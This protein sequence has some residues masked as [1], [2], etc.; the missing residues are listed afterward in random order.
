MSK[1]FEVN[2]EGYTNVYVDGCC[3]NQGT[4]QS[5]AGYGIFWGPNNKNNLAGQ[6]RK[7]ATNNVAEIQGATV[8]IQQAARLGIKK[9]CVVTDS[10]NVYDAVTEHL[11]Q[12]KKNGWHRL[13]EGHSKQPIK[14]RAAY[15]KLDKAIHGNSKVAI[16]FQ[17]VEAHSGNQNHNAADRL[18][19]EGAR[20]HY[21]N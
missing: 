6:S 18:A 11:P 20:L 9:L 4:P 12:W 7:N 17:L 1:K 2:R 21:N 5:A 16:K 19:A 10:E 13:Y 14:D 3:L 8:A 15:E